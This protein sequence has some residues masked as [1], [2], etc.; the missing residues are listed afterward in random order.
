MN[1]SKIYKDGDAC[2]KYIQ[3]KKV[4]I[5]GF[6]NQGKAQA[7]NLR[8][9]GINVYIGGRLG[10]ESLNIAKEPGFKTGTIPNTVKLSDI[11]DRG[12]SVSREVLTG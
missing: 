1:I 5:I 7:L 9:S 10:G 3:S 4:G 8:D 11:N 12:I 2:L 6:G